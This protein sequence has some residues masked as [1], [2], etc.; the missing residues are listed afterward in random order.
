MLLLREEARERLRYIAFTC[1]VKGL[2]ASA[3]PVMS[4]TLV[5]GQYNY[6]LGCVSSFG[7]PGLLSAAGDRATPTDSLIGLSISHRSKSLGGK[8]GDE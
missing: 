7:D 4:L 1:F 6:S 3:A 5:G 2:G 8:K